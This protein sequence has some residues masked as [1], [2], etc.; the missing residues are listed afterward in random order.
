MTIRYQ[1]HV[2][3]FLLTQFVSCGFSNVYLN[4]NIILIFFNK[5]KCFTM[6]ILSSFRPDH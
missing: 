5:T 3:C 1:V 2:A 4:D 6:Y